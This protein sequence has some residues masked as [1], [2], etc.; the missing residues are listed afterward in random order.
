MKVAQLSLTLCNPMDYTIHEIP[1]ARILKWV[2]LPFSRG[3]FPTQG[4]NPRPSA[5]QVDSL[6]ADPTG[7]PKHI[8]VGRLSLLQWIFPTQGLNQGLLCCRQIL[9][10]LSYQESPFSSLRNCCINTEYGEF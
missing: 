1:Q 5:L 10:Q 2:A 6:P 8:G 7:K 3:I 9:S 4:S